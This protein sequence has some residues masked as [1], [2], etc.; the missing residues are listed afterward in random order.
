MIG[1]Y[2]DKTFSIL[3]AVRREE[4]GRIRQAAE[5]LAEAIRRDQMIFTFGTGHSSLLAS[6]GLYRAG[7]LAC[8]SAILEPTTTFEVGAVSSSL[9]E[10]RPGYASYVLDRYDLNAGDA[11]VVYSNSGTNALPVEVTSE[12]KARGVHTV[13]ITSKAYAAQAPVT[14][15]SGDTLLSVADLIIDNHVPPGDAVVPVSGDR[16]VASVSTVVGSF[17]WNALLAEVVAQVEAAGGE[18]PI[19]ISSN[20]PGAKQ[21]NDALVKKYRPKVRH[22]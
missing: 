2:F 1:T 18:A 7:G 22:L 6:E 8:V 14:A 3:D 10:R 12:A 4:E 17:I 13:A 15:A 16:C 9:F 11:L 5:V 20:M 19:Y 21:N